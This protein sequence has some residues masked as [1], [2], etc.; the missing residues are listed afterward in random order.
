MLTNSA[1]PRT[2]T[3]APYSI[4]PSLSYN[5]DPRCDM[6]CEYCPP[7]YENYQQSERVLSDSEAA[8]L[9]TAAS[10][11]G[12]TVFRLSGGEPLLRPDH[13][14]F[15][16]GLLGSLGIP[17]R[18]LRL[19]TN[20][21]RLAKYAPQLLS[22]GIDVV[23]VSLDT[24]DPVLFKEITRSD[25]YEKVVRGIQK[26][27]SI[28]MRVE[29]NMVFTQRTAPGVLDLIEFCQRESV[30]VLKI[31]DLVEYDDPEYFRTGYREMSDLHSRLAVLSSAVSS[32]QLSTGRGVA[33]R[34]YD[35]DGL[36]V[37]VKDCRD[38][39]S[40]SETFC[41]GCSLYPC[42]EGFYNLTLNSD[43]K[44]KPCRLVTNQFA[45]VFDSIES[46]GSFEGAVG[47]MALKL[48][49]MLDEFY[50]SMRF[51]K[52]WQPGGEQA[53]RVRSPR[54]VDS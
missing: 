32:E 39:T 29:L 49:A 23:K 9:F 3:G 15:L 4:V 52:R 35:L 22:A 18:N 54:R 17:Q 28:G 36:Q 50:S 14:L 42:Q 41:A 21:S 13:V 2:A 46:E 24:S 8:V 10:Q 43:G 6:R 1:P 34:R 47:A 44:L 37:L 31:L 40:Y 33:M 11:V 53:V 48:Q 19:N 16:A 38:G 20:G 25:A 12:I 51:E 5:V 7:F 27:T 30:P 26:A 45:N